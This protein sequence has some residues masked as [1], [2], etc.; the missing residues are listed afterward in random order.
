MAKFPPESGQTAPLNN[1]QPGWDQ[2]RPPN[3]EGVSLEKLL[4]KPELQLLVLR[5]APNQC[6]QLLVAF[7]EALLGVCWVTKA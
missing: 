2:L 6:K 5:V 1:T 3:R 7:P 4:Q